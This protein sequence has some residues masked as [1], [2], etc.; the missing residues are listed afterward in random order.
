M[1]SAA[2]QFISVETAIPF[3][4][5]FMPTD[6]ELKHAPKMFDIGWDSDS[7]SK[8][9]WHEITCILRIR[10]FCPSFCWSFAPL[11]VVR[12]L[13]PSW[14][15]ICPCCQEHEDSETGYL[16]EGTEI[17]EDCICHL[18]DE[19]TE[20]WVQ[21]QYEEIDYMNVIPELGQATKQ[22]W[23]ED[24]REKKISVR[25]SFNG[26]TGRVRICIICKKEA[27]KNISSHQPVQKLFEKWGIC[28]LERRKEVRWILECKEKQ[29]SKDG[30]PEMEVSTKYQVRFR[31][32]G[33]SV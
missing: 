14:E 21:E 22:A 10:A 29:R 17:P 19:D 32:P 8:M 26:D 4:S 20:D 1:R 15:E 11:D 30:N 25:F 31:R 16:L 6:A 27:F 3:I 33:F 12:G 23:L 9:V 13:I 5:T 2:V 24:L 28:N 18:K 7:D